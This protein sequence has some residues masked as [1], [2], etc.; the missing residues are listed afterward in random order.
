MSSNYIQ[1]K[2]NFWPKFSFMRKGVSGGFSLLEQE[3][4]S[5]WGVKNLG[6]NHK[7]LQSRQLKVPQSQDGVMGCLIYA[8]CPVNPIL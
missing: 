1:K 8:P 4:G 3:I 7:I 6:P 2:T 5:D